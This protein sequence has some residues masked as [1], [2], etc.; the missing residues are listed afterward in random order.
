MESSLKAHPDIQIIEEASPRMILVEGPAN[1]VGELGK[2]TP[3]WLTV[4]E[5]EVPRPETRKLPK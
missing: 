3:G 1:A 2:Q 5:A 4:P